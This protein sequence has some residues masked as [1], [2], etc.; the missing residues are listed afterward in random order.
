MLVVPKEKP[1]LANLNTYYLKLDKLIEHCQG[2][3]GAG[4]LYFRSAS[5]L[6]VL[7]FDTEDILNGYFSDKT[8]ELYNAAAVDR[9]MR[10]DF[11]YNFCV[12]IYRVPRE[13]VYLWSK[14]PTAEKIYK[15]LSTAFTDLDGL[16]KKL[17]AE[18]L[19]GYIEIE[20]HGVQESGLI[21]FS[22]GEIIGGS[23][24]W[25]QGDGSSPKS[26]TTRLIKAAKDS[27][28]TFQVSRIPMADPSVNPQ[29]S[30][31]TR[32]QNEVVKMLEEFIGIFESLVNTRKNQSADFNTMIRKKFVE[33]AER[34]EFLDPFAAEFEYSHRKIYF[35][36][37]AG[38][39]ELANGI[40]VSIKELALEIGAEDEFGKYLAPWLNKYEK[41]LGELGVAV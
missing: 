6:G 13:N 1:V 14:T 7:F 11:S 3:F 32:S 30:K 10:P 39:D 9:L 5:A 29:A 22:G 41:F 4:G 16:I 8:G 36:G 33:N 31:A 21:F 40:I 34:F 28:G 12:D 37:D 19:T 18:K 25:G 15:D 17:S 35:N 27:G 24:P 2:E 20:L 38:D 26:D 23:Y